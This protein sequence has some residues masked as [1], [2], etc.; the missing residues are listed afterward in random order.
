MIKHLFKLA[1][2]RKGANALVVVEIFVSFLVVFGVALLGVQYASTYWR[3]LGFSR[4]GVL[5]VSVDSWIA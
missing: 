3:P 4:E 1:W 2:N 5:N